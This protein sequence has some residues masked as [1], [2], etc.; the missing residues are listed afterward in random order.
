MRQDIERGLVYDGYAGLGQVLAYAGHQGLVH[1]Q[2]RPWARVA[3]LRSL[4]QAAEG[5]LGEA[6]PP[7]RLVLIRFLVAVIYFIYGVER[8]DCEWLEELVERDRVI[9]RVIAWCCC[10]QRQ[11]GANASS[12]EIV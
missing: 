10:C 2:S 8:Q 9:N 7:V 11:E 3:V 12:S 1:V 4:L 6:G 5:A